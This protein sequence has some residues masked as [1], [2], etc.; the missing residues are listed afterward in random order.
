MFRN[1]WARVSLS[2]LILAH[3]PALAHDVRAQ[4]ARDVL[5]E[6]KTDSTAWQR[7]LQH[8]I[9]S[10]NVYLV[11]TSVDI[12][13]QPWRIE[14][15]GN[16]PQTPL[17]LRQLRTI[18]RARPVTDSDTLT[19]TLVIGPLSIRSD[20]ADVTVRTDFAKRCPNGR[21][22]GFGNIDRVVIRRA[23]Q[24]YWG[25]ARSTGVVHGARAGCAGPW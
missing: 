13:P 8:V 14:L 2:V 1:R 10:L 24:G 17:L 11:R 12:N 6:F 19:F 22:G 4:P 23:P 9:G 18:L 20:S 25:A 3:A 5:G 7:V 21:M 15:P 16:E